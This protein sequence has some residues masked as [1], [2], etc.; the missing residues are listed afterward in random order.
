MI[1]EAIN[2]HASI[3]A[4]AQ[5][6]GMTRQN[7]YKGRS[8]RLSAEA[9]A[10]LVEQLVRGGRAQPRLGGRKLFKIL[11]PV[12]KNEG[13]RLG[14]DR[15][16]DFLRGKGSL[17]PPLPKSPGTTRFEPSLPV[18]HNLATGLELTGPNQAWVPI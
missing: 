13:I 2:R 8:A 4:L 12:F 5:K 11:T 18:F 17:C 6:L 10:E 7:F 16:F 3:S 14:W 9:D 1:G 15:F